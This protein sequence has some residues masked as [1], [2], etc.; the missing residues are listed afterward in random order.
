MPRPAMTETIEPTYSRVITALYPVLQRITVREW[1]GLENVPSTGGFV[2]ACN[3]TSNMDHFPLAHFLVEAGRAPHYLAK[4]SLFKP[5]GVKQIMYGCGQIPVYRGTSRATSALSAAKEALERGACVCIYPEGTITR[6]PDFWPMTGKTGAARLALET[7][8]PLL[9]IAM[10]G[11]RDIMWPY[12]DKIP[13]LLPAKLVQVSAGPPVDLDDLRDQ[14][15]TA[16]T[17][18]T[19]TT[20]LMDQITGL[21]EDVRGIPAPAERFDPRSHAADPTRRGRTA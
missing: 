1:S 9:P 2:A 7:G 5:P 12:R 20:R 6:Q 14:P 19:A 21:L 3:H 18:R 16:T 13:K 4:D 8:V 11:T 15:I 17:L 10:W